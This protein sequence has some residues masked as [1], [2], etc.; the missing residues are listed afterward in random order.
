MNKHYHTLKAQTTGEFEIKELFD[1]EFLVV[2]VVAMIEGVRF[3]ANGD[4]GG[5]LGLTEEFG[6]FV[7]GWNNRP[8]VANHPTIQGEF[9]SAN[10]PAVLEDFG[11][12]TVMNSFI[13]D[14]TLVMEAWLSLSLRDQSEKAE[15][16]LE[17]IEN[18]EVIEVSVGF[19]TDVE[20]ISGSFNGE[21]FAGVWRNIVPDHLAFLDDE[22]IGACSIADGCGAARSDTTI[23][24]QAQSQSII[25][26]P[27]GGLRMLQFITGAKKKPSP[28]NLKKQAKKDK[29]GVV[30]ETLSRL[31][32]NAMP[33]GI[34]SGDI[35]TLLQAE[36]VKQYQWVF[37][38]GFTASHAVFEIFSESE[39]RWMLLQQEFSM[40]EDGVA[41][42]TSDPEE[43]K[44]LT[45]I[46]P[47]DKHDPEEDEEEEDNVNNNQQED[48]TMPNDKTKVQEGEDT[49]ESPEAG[50]DTI[51]GG[52]STDTIEGGDAEETKTEEESK[53][54]ASEET[55]EETTE[56]ASEGGEDSV[57]TLS[58]YID[59]A[60]KG[61][62]DEL[63]ESVKVHSDRKSEMIKGLLGSG[64]CDFDESYLKAQS[65][66]I[67]ENLNKLA[68][69]QSY[70]GRV[71]PQERASEE[72]YTPAP[73][74]FEKAKA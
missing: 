13:K 21:E 50:T 23:Q 25:Q 6:K 15:V 71:I 70:A 9:V 18:G 57:S 67:L 35:Q 17:R 7:D 12:G 54:E 10:S 19:F 37:V 22:L 44:F 53:E 5:E 3:P 42:F 26:E 68:G 36:L 8:V 51:E 20:K 52:D 38:I 56:T 43:V 31:A 64:K 30:L 1:N 73:K 55:Q 69:V 46:I 61:I 59:N 16:M 72:N 49:T 48:N 4:S 24:V 33:E 2:P 29:S 65:V 62:K 34:L 39:D 66:A 32:A 11:L 63:E 58:E 47:L 14:D 27:E 41:S 45:R 74:A 60:P 28:K 40:D